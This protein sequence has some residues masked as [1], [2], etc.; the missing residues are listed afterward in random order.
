MK[1]GDDDPYRIVRSPAGKCADCSYSKEIFSAR[2]SLFYLCELSERDPSFPKYP[3]LPVLECAGYVL[4]EE[5]SARDG[6]VN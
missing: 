1:I 4:K 5:G 2:G 6:P 3:R